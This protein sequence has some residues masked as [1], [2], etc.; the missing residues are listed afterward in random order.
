M[1]DVRRLVVVLGDQLDRSSAAFDDFDP[2][3]DVVWMAEAAEESTKVWVSKPRITMF[4]AAMRHFAAELTE[5]GLRIDYRALDEPGT[6]AELAAEL[7]AAITRHGPESVVLVEPGE[8][9]IRE[10]LRTAIASTGVPLDERADR[11][12]LCSTAEFAEH[13]AGRRGIRMENFYREQR[14]RSGILMDDGRPAGGAWNFDSENR[15]SFGSDGPGLVPPPARFEPDGITRAVIELV[16]DRFAEHPGSLDRFGWPVTR[17]D[18]LVALDRFVEERLADFGHWQDAMWSAEPWLYHSLVSA[19]LN[20]K[21]LDPREV[22]ARVEDAWRSGNVPIEAAE[23]YVRQIIGWREYVRGIYWTRMP[24]YASG[25]ALDANEP[26]PDWFWTGETELACLRD[27][28]GQTLEYG[29]AHHIQRL[30]VT[31]LY[32]QLL[33][34]DPRQVHEWYLAV[35]VDAVE[36][37]ELP[38]VLGMSQF[39]DGGFMA[40]KPYVATGK[41]ID[42]MS[43]HCRSCRFRPEQRVGEDA[44]PF[45]TLYWDFLS[46]HEERFA[47]HPRMALQV[48]NLARIPEGERIE[49]ARRAATLRS[50][51]SPAAVQRGPTAL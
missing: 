29:Y 50:A 39:A 23:G 28:I 34:V 40:S 14:R 20:L 27:A 18:A 21:L 8:W 1:N 38:N 2:H 4:L 35:Y 3:R 46:R 15:R 6:A 7:I 22:V 49:I 32:A 10:D 47:R 24:D 9:R 42:R 37:V 33:G 51:V 36:W 30:M 16:Q 41:Y 13:A 44:C 5:E 25:N 48:K 17:A 26:L 12:F 45:T 43:N 19:A 31:G 11:H